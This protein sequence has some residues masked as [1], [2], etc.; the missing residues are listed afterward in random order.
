MEPKTGRPL[1][2]QIKE[3]EPR[4]SGWARIATRELPTDINKETFSKMSQLTK[5]MTVIFHHILKPLMFYL[6]KSKV[7]KA[8][9]FF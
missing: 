2:F 1:R 7:T 5:V 9:V 8:T 6:R 4:S 3:E